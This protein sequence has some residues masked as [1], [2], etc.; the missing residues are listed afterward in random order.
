MVQISDGS[1][2]QLSLK[3]QIDYSLLASL[4]HYSYFIA[5]LYMLEPL[6]SFYF[7]QV[8]LLEALVLE[9]SDV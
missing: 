1:A 5:S 9:N 2:L 7:L 8:A 4:Q 3:G 6:T